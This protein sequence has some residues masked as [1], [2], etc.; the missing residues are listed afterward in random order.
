MEHVRGGLHPGVHVEVAAATTGVVGSPRL[1]LGAGRG[2]VDELAVAGVG[3][4]AGRE[5]ALQRRGDQQWLERRPRLSAGAGRAGVRRDDRVELGLVAQ[6]PA[7]LVVP[8]CGV[9]HVARA[10]PERPERHR[11]DRAVTRDDRHDAAERLL[12]DLLAGLALVGQEVHDRLLRSDLEPR[13]ERGV[14]AQARLVDRGD[15]LVLGRTERVEQVLRDPHGLGCGLLVELPGDEVDPVGLVG[16][17][18]VR[19]VCLQRLGLLALGDLW[20]DVAAG[21][22]LPQDDVAAFAGVARVGDRVVALGRADHPGDRR[23][24]P[25]GQVVHRGREVA[26]RGLAD[27]VDALA[28]RDPVEI[29]LEDLLLGQQLLD[30]DR[31]QRLL[32]LAVVAVLG[33]PLH[34]DVGVLD[35]LLG[36]RRG[37]ALDLPGDE[38]AGGGADDRLDVDAVVLPELVVLGRDDGVDEVLRDVLQRHHQP[39]LTER[40]LRDLRAVGGVDEGVL[41][42]RVG[43][44]QGRHVEDVALHGLDG[45]GREDGSRQDQCSDHRGDARADDDEQ[46]QTRHGAGGTAEEDGQRGLRGRWCG[47]GESWCGGPRGPDEANDGR[48]GHVP[49]S[50]VHR[51]RRVAGAHRMPVRP[52]RSWDRAHDA[53]DEE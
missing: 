49:S 53:V 50:T 10:V 5:A 39:G 8:E 38:V 37:A 7:L 52:A 43:V 19:R 45:L 22:H 29:A 21:G 18:R 4:P 3:G 14:D 27:P 32:Q 40:D 17:G 13:V 12:G 48:R 34:V 24:L 23:R 6:D 46:D 47:D 42:D 41:V 2:S 26:L 33:A 9:A 1:L 31:P 35:E 36:D 20:A 28:E 11:A 16:C 44:G 25:Q 15:A 51:Q 30:L